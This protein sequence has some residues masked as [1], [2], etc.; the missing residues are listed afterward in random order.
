MQEFVT[1]VSS[2]NTGTNRTPCQD[3]RTDIDRTTLVPS[4]IIDNNATPPS[5][6]LWKPRIGII[7]KSTTQNFR[8]SDEL[9]ASIGRNFSNDP[10]AIP[11]SSQEFGDELSD[12]SSKYIYT[13][14][15]VKL[16]TNFV[17][18]V[19]PQF[20]NHGLSTFNTLDKSA[21]IWSPVTIIRR[22]TYF[23]YWSASDHAVGQG[24][25][26][27]DAVGDYSE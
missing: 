22:S 12:S 16:S 1:D 23:T 7:R 17:N 25:A 2:N 20:V 11:V 6:F 9:N 4:G 24:A 5:A 3:R 26:V 10:I 14:F 19:S 27:G 13:H 8:K 18:P 21:R 15:R